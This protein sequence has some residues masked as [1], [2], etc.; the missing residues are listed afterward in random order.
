MKTDTEFEE[1]LQKIKENAKYLKLPYS[2]HNFRQL[3]QEHINLNSS[4]VEFYNDLF[5]KEA[6]VRNQ[7]G[8]ENR[9]RHANFPYKKYLSDLDV[10]CLP[11]DAQNRLQ[12]LKTLDFVR[13]GQNIILAGN[14]GTGK[15]H[16]AIGLGIEACKE[17]FRV[18]F[19]SAPTLV[20]KL[21]EC[22]S[23]RTLTSIQRQFEMY[24]LIILDVLRL[25]IF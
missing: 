8:K 17:G 2:Y 15:T 23:N 10:S 18:L 5:Q 14:P 9:I 12:L 24:D 4:I 13:S 20:N 22:K 25:Y 6:D 1:T 11:E 16:I 3:V 21:K 19:T 7:N